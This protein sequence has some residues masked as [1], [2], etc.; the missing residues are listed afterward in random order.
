[1]HPYLAEVHI[2]QQR[3]QVKSA[4]ERYRMTHDRREQQSRRRG[5]RWTGIRLGWSWK[6]TLAGVR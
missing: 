2:R 1:M 6:P 5:G 4:A 3:Q